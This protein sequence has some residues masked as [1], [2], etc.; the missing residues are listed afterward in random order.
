M[1]LTNLTSL[2][3]SRNQLTSV[4]EGI[5]ELTNL[6][7]LD[8]AGNQLTSVP[9]GIKELTNLTRLY[10]RFNQLTS[11]PE[12]IKELTNL[13]RLDLASNQLTSVP[14]CL[15]EM[16]LPII[17]ETQRYFINGINLFGNPLERPPVDVVKEGNKAI[18]DYFESLQ[19]GP[20][21]VLNEVK[22]IFVGEGGAGKTSLMKRLVKNEF[23]PKE[24]RTHGIN[25]EHWHYR[26]NNKRITAHLW[27]FGGQD[28]LQATHQFFLTRRSL[29]VLVLDG[30]KEE[31]TERWLK[32]IESFGGDSPILVLLNKIDENPLFEVD[33]RLLQ[34]KYKG[35]QAF[36]RISCK[37][38]DGIGQFKK[39]LKVYLTQLESANNEWAESWFR[40]KNTLGRMK[41]K[42]E[43]FIGHGMYEA[44]C[45]KHKVREGH[46]DTLAGWLHDLGVILH[47]EELDLADMHILEPHWVTQGA[48]KIINYKPLSEETK[49]ILELSKL[50]T[51]LRKKKDEDFDYPVDKQR[52]LVELMKKFEL[53][54]E[55][56]SNTVLIP[57]LQ[58]IQQPAFT[59]A[60][61]K[62]LRFYF[63]YGYLP[64]VILPRF[65]VRMHHDIKENLRWRSGVILEDKEI[66]AIASIKEDRKENRIYVDVGGQQKKE[67]FGV[68]RKQIRDINAGFQKLGVEEWVPLPDGD[69]LAVEYAE[70]IGH[71]KVG[72]REYFNGK[73]GRTFSVEELLNGIERPEERKREGKAIYDG[74]IIIEE[75]NVQAENGDIINA[76]QYEW[77]SLP[78]GRRLKRGDK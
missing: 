69:G 3:L 22:V 71:E 8:L 34:D 21:K 55:Y 9:E 67:Y 46:R 23:D 54:H 5:K 64:P 78:K 41:A 68:I 49:G 38:K 48:Y 24:S 73:L 20:T 13:T 72:R 10:L 15:L 70:L 33:R 56:E 30:R 51:I 52:F 53:C 66:K 26:H 43:H 40:V 1:K 32:M 61:E 37:D 63:A 35:I 57:S 11:V 12:G 2:G 31:D 76:D 59:I 16:R 50:R 19:D 18:Q 74:C 36:Y 29:Y 6:T 42:G 75:Q 28:I 27:D 17:W 62:P 7:S 58:D 4:P 65:T 77:N 14:E 44:L 39:Q 45:T 60:D 47:F 25:L